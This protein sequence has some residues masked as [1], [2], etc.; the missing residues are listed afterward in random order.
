MRFSKGENEG[1]QLKA[2]PKDFISAGVT[3]SHPVG[4]SGALTVNSARRI[5]L[6]DANEIELPGYTTVDARLGYTW[7]LLTLTLEGFNL[8]DE[9]YSTTGFPDPAGT[10]AV[11]YYPAAG[12]SV[13]LGLGLRL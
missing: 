11:F 10:G 2:I 6:D 1:N 12:R 13:R 3:A 7:Q 9:E 5:W 4:F 8:F